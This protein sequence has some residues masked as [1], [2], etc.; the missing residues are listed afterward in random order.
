[1][2]DTSINQADFKVN[3]LSSASRKTKK[4]PIINTSTVCVQLVW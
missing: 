4:L 2:V 3:T 1:M